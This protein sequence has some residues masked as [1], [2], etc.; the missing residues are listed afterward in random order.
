MVSA[1]YDALVGHVDGR[2][3]RDRGGLDDARKEAMLQ[4]AR[5]LS[6]T[7]EHLHVMHGCMAAS[8]AESDLLFTM[9]MIYNPLYHAA[10]DNSALLY[11]AICVV[12]VTN[13]HHSMV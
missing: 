13:A 8:N 4:L 1:A 9:A 3:E 11:H 7:G 5:S 6:V 2:K 10:K 12:C